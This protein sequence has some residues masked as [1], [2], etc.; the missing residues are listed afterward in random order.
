[1]ATRADFQFWT[2]SAWVTAVNQGY[3][4]VI[5]MEITDT[6]NNPKRLEVRLN[7]AA[8]D[9][10]SDTPSEQV[11]PFGPDQTNE[12]SEFQ[13]VR[14][15]APDTGVILFYGKIYRLSE[16]YHPHRGQ[17]LK[18]TAYD[19][20]KELV[21]MPTDDKDG[22]FVLQNRQRHQV[23]KDIINSSNEASLKIPADN[24][25][26]I[27]ITNNIHAGTDLLE[28]SVKTAENITGEGNVH[29]NTG[30][31]KAL[32]AILS[33]A[34]SDPH[35]AATR[36]NDF[37]WDFYLSD[38]FDLNGGTS[39][40]GNH[41][42]TQNFNYFKRGSR[43]AALESNPAN[44]K[45]LH[46]EYPTSFGGFTETGTHRTMLPEYAFERDGEEIYTEGLVNTSEK[47]RS[48]DSSNNTIQEVR[49]HIRCE[50]WEVGSISGEFTWKGKAF[51]LREK[52]DLSGS[53]VAEVLR[54]QSGGT[55][56][57]LGRIQW[58]DSD[59][60]D[61]TIL[62]SYEIGSNHQAMIDTYITGTSA[63]TVTG[64]TSGRTFSITPSTGRLK[65]KQTLSRAYRV[66]RNP[67]SGADG[68][69]RKMFNALT[70]SKEVG[71]RG[72]IRMLGVP[73]T[74]Y[75]TYA[76]SASGNTLTLSGDPWVYGFKL[77]MTIAQ[78]D[79]AGD[80]Q[81]YGWV[82][83]VSNSSV[84]TAKLNSGNWNGYSGASNKIRVF[85]PVRAGSYVY[86]TNQLQHIASYQFVNEVTYS[87]GEAMMATNF[88][89]QATQAA[90]PYGVK[91]LGVK[92]SAVAS[93]INEENAP[94]GADTD[95]FAKAALPWT[96]MPTNANLEPIIPLG[97]NQITVNAST[98]SLGGGAY[99]YS[100]SQANS[101]TFT[102][103]NIIYFDPDTSTTALQITPK[104]SYTNNT[105]HI[106]IGWCK[107]VSGGTAIVYTGTGAVGN[108]IPAGEIADGS[109]T[110]A[111]IANDAITS[112]LLTPAAQPW[113][114]NIRWRP[115]ASSPHLNVRWDNGSDN[116]NAVLKF[117][118]GDI[119]S[120]VANDYATV[121][122]SNM[123]TGTT[124]YAFLAGVSGTQT[125]YFD[126]SYAQATG[127]TRILL[128]TITTGSSNA[129]GDSP[130]I[131]PFN[132]KSP[133]IN[134]TSIAADA[135]SGNHI[136][137]NTI[138]S[139]MISTGRIQGDK[140]AVN[141]STTFASGSY[142]ITTNDATQALA[143]A[144]AAS[145]AAGS[146][147]T[148]AGTKNTT[149]RDSISNDAAGQDGPVANKVGDVW[150]NT[151]ANSLKVY[152]CASISGTR[153]V[154]GTNWILRDDAGAV[155]NA[156]TNINGGRIETQAIVL[157]SGGAGNPNNTNSILVDDD[158]NYSSSS[159]R[160]LLSN[161]GIYGY[162]SSTAQFYLQASDG[163]AYFAGG[164]VIA[165]SKGLAVL[166]NGTPGSNNAWVG[167]G[168]YNGG[169]DWNNNV[170]FS[171]SPGE[172]GTLT[173]LFGSGAGSASAG[174]VDLNTSLSNTMI[175][176]NSAGMEQ[177]GPI[178]V[179]T[180]GDNDRWFLLPTDKPLSGEVL[181]VLASGN[182]KFNSPHNTYWGSDYTST[183]RVKMNIQNLTLD[184]AKI[185]DL[186]AR[187]FN[188]REFDFNDDG[189]LQFNADGS[190]K[191]TDTAS[192]D[193]YYT[194]FGYIAEEV[195]L[196]LPEIVQ[197]D[198]TNT[199]LTV[200]YKALTVLL[201]EELKKLKA[202]VDTL[203]AG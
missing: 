12:L 113:T 198:R 109:I 26:I 195:N 36:E 92:P 186:T 37:G 14:V 112:V 4:A 173:T 120:I 201:I 39:N 16:E 21:D 66:T 203:E 191:Y 38:A 90:H 140:I 56:Y 115:A 59:S 28:S 164:N 124:Y 117:Q 91:G 98:L 83:A 155:N 33:V 149:F 144:A 131:L 77:G 94:I 32:S 3:N 176:W 82:S 35:S 137:A 95:T 189:S 194:N 179:N 184:S 165:D 187:S 58:Q 46:L 132:S 49:K 97:S 88:K 199:P 104:A 193:T 78:I 168:F 202:R 65:T 30:N 24:I 160:V 196:I 111:K 136:Q 157:K 126:T 8:A 192:T 89:T 85:I 99:S 102:G 145:V 190:I 150:V 107:E 162:N 18:V 180:H 19:N 20:L 170:I 174:R 135:I 103:H 153:R 87:E 64:M 185:F 100:I 41:T 25:K 163:K 23:I 84:I 167:V 50:V 114:S 9:P 121:E 159:S 13:K 81:A 134:A 5:S 166:E 57:Q 76:T 52:V 172:R 108:T 171:L 48:A 96:L 147:N 178:N 71:I 152:T 10:F 40:D 141:G 15:L 17:L 177:T 197:L 156:T 34:S 138:T 70:K 60:G 133:T 6:L 130:V 45:G 22:P 73:V 51:D 63:I 129:D 123:S 62:I 54:V 181:K 183:Q 119:V 127:P 44:Y 146:A 43:P 188:F 79:D 161:T 154:I 2:G 69:R 80:V 1:M 61:G 175:N 86:A 47:T 142:A 105:E 151:H 42:P 169:S 74:Y 122:G 29:I 53:D 148:L 116:T 118:S 11:G 158:S 68:L 31:K 75:D 139:G 72:N 27:G 128:A 182:G 67:Q 101:S 125:M 7:D 55:W 200:D 110:T 93:K 143:D 106:L